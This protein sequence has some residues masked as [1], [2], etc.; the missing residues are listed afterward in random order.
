MSGK[1]RKTTMEY[2][3][4]YNGVKMPMLGFGVYQVSEEDTEQAVLTAL[5]A[6]YRLID[7]ARAYRNE[8][9]VGRAI[10]ASGIPRGEIFLTTKLWVSDFSYEGALAA[11]EKS[12]RR[13]G[14]D[15]IDL[16][17]LHQPVGDYCSAWRALEK[18]YA[19]KALRAIGMAN[20]Y[21]HVL[22]DLCETFQVRPMVNQVELH[23]FF[24]QPGN[25]EVMQEYGVVPEA[26][27]PFAEGKH[28]IFRHPVLTGI[29]AKYGKTAA[30]TALRWN[31][32]RGV[33]VIP[34]SVHEERIRQ[35]FDVFDFELD[36]QD[37][38][39]IQ[40]LDLGRSD[41]VNHFDPA[42]VKLLH[43]FRVD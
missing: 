30:Q 28:D 5:Q 33:V 37:M 23:P 22:C 41:I 20:C 43:S 25:L 24:Q 1:G 7:T 27:G 15:Y 8:A 9:A 14:T 13:L 35:N 2:R 17:L 32:Q 19:D 36:K 16:M 39:R 3:T 40:A 42:F 12:L 26:W 6:G 31:I 21:P 11:T 4:L 10:K 34:K 38:E 29:G 18:F